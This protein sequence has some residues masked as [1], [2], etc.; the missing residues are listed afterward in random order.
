M[1]LVALFF[2]SFDSFV[3]CRSLFVWTLVGCLDF[4]GIGIC[5]DDG[6]MVRS[7]IHSG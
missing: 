6:D 5:D 2:L 4:G 3:L 1:L 7:F